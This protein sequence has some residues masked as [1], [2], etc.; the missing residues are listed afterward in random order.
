MGYV[1]QF[2]LFLYSFI[3]VAAKLNVKL[4]K[5]FHVSEFLHMCRRET[6]L[7]IGRYSCGSSRTCNVYADCRLLR[8]MYF[9]WSRYLCWI[10]LLNINN[11]NKH[12]AFS[13]F[14]KNINYSS[15]HEMNNMRLFRLSVSQAQWITSHYVPWNDHNYWL[16]RAL[17]CHVCTHM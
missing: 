2:A 1:L 7:L 5:G 8:F 9:T 14:L 16:P 12:C 6:I 15:L 4:F 3:F 11:S 13:W 10:L 17:L